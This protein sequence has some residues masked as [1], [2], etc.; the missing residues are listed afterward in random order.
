M[1]MDYAHAHKRAAGNAACIRL[2]LLLFSEG[3]DVPLKCSTEAN[4]AHQSQPHPEHQLH[5]HALIVG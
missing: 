3:V 4:A 5:R 1:Y 2:C